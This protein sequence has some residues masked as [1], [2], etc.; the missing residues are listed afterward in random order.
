M[1]LKRIALA[2]A[3]VAGALG[4]AVPATASPDGVDS[5]VTTKMKGSKEAPGPGDANGKGEFS[6]TLSGDLDLLLVLR[7]QHRSADGRA[8]PH[9][10]AGGRA[11]CVVTL[12]LPT[13]RRCVGMCH[14]GCEAARSDQGRP[15]G[16]YVNVHTAD[17][18]A[19][20]IRGQLSELAPLTLPTGPR[21]GGSNRSPGL[22]P[23]LLYA[24][25]P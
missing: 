1:H 25:A 20:A 8:H 24:A 23:P 16:Y 22:L 19:G 13:E 15:K 14:A 12:T 4:I 6:A 7:G 17:F 21:F 2:T 11:R 3:L 9:G 5:T 10:P 18:P